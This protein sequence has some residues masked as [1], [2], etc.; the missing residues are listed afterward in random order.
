MKMDIMIFGAPAN[1]VSGKTLWRTPL[2]YLF[3]FM[4]FIISAGT[5]GAQTQR[6][7]ITEGQIAPA[8]I[9]GHLR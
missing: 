2:L 4:L 8:D 3:A 7:D 1:T 9:T 5:V 6:L